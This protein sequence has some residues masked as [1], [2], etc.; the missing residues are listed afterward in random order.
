MSNYQVKL[1]MVSK[2]DRKYFEYLNLNTK[3]HYSIAVID[4]FLK[5]IQEEVQKFKQPV[6]LR[7]HLIEIIPVEEGKKSETVELGTFEYEVKPDQPFVSEHRF[8]QIV[9]TEVYL[10]SSDVPDAYKEEV[11]NNI[12]ESKE[13]LS[14]QL[15]N[16]QSKPKS[17]SKLK[18]VVVNKFLKHRT[19][20]AEP[21][22]RSENIIEDLSDKAKSSENEE[23]KIEEVSEKKETVIEEKEN[24]AEE[25]ENE[26]TEDENIIDNENDQSENKE[27]AEDDA[28]ENNEA[29][30]KKS[31]DNNEFSDSVAEQKPEVGSYFD[32]ISFDRLI[33]IPDFKLP[34]VKETDRF[35]KQSNDPVENKRL[36]FLFDRE[37]RLASYKEKR[38]IEIY[39]NLL[40]KYHDYLLSNEQHIDARLQEYEQTRTTFIEEYLHK[41]KDEMNEKREKKIKTIEQEQKSERDDFVEKQKK[42][43]TRFDEEQKNQQEEKMTEYK[44][45]LQKETKAEKDSAHQ[46]FDEK[47]AALKKELTEKVKADVYHYV[48]LDQQSQIQALN[49]E[50]FE[51]NEETYKQVDNHLSVWQTEVD[52]KQQQDIKMQADSL[53]QANYEAEK[54]KSQSE[55]LSMKAQDREMESNAQRLQ[56]QEL[57]QKQAEMAYQQEEQR[58]KA[59]E[60]DANHKAAEAKKRGAERMIP[61]NVRKIGGIVAGAVLVLFILIMFAF[62]LF[63]NDTATYAELID[64]E[65]YVEAYERYP[66][67]YED[68][69]QT[70]HESGDTETINY[71]AGEAPDNMTAKLYQ[72]VNQGEPQAI[73]QAYQNVENPEQL[74]DDM[75]ISVVDQY[76]NQQDY[77]QATAV[78]EYINDARYTERIEEV[79]SYMNIKAEL[80]QVIENS[81]DNDEVENAENTLAQIDAIFNAQE[82]SE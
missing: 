20:V 22:N 34:R 64:E 7:F 28:E 73:I 50:L 49:D 12:K 9:E 42:E 35:L 10:N 13:K 15:N 31:E 71:L 74:N 45:H 38:L 67:R 53:A 16:Q 57:E 2:T 82:E 25:S 60:V 41:F 47:K 79:E 62:Q 72:A 81:D 4:E 39:Q 77:Q 54:E 70:A 1:I 14:E 6:K 80:E 56:A 36:S 40:E 19:D 78:N 44:A 63:F 24:N 5:H 46:K 11:L 37:T 52:N 55:I 43:L 21:E 8:Y 32:D 48:L 26:I 51:Y 18:D 58:L 61:L 3:K 30:E 23:E 66:N 65:E 29:I 69:L 75:L 59:I 76:L 17:K 68:L 33:D 27:S